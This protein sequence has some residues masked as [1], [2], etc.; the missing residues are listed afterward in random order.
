MKNI[1]TSK[2]KTTEDNAEANIGTSNLF[3]LLNI[4]IK[5]NHKI[6]SDDN[7]MITEEKTHTTVSLFQR[8]KMELEEEKLIIRDIDEIEIGDFIE[9]QGVLKT[10]PLIDMLA[11]LK[12]LMLLV[13]L[14]TDNKPKENKG[15]KDKLLSDNNSNFAH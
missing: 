10:N 1:Q 13:N 4:G 3:A 14:F 5:G 6:G 11:G 12:E 7:Q 2:N 8:L 9:I 15:R